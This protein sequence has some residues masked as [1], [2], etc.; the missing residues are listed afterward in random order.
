MKEKEKNNYQAP[1]LKVIKLKSNH[2]LLQDSLPDDI[3]VVH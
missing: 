3:P 1:K 2:P